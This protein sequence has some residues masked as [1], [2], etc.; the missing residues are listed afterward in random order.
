MGH[1]VL[2]YYSLIFSQTLR[3]AS[4][5]ENAIEI[6]TKDLP[7]DGKETESPSVCQILRCER[8]YFP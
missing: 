6:T 7:R 5:T 4:E 2:K 3:I 1:R 8:D